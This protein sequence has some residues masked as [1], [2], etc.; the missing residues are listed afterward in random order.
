MRKMKLQVQGP[1]GSPFR[2]L[3]TV[4]GISLAKPTPEEAVEAIRDAHI[5]ITMARVDRGWMTPNQAMAEL[6]D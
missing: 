5:N 3:A 4:G 2:W 6:F 1:V